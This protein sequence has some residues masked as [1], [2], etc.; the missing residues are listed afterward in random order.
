M[1]LQRG[2]KHVILVVVLLMTGADGGCSSETRPGQ[3]ASDS[4]IQARDD[5]A[6]YNPAGTA[7]APGFVNI[8]YAGY[9]GEACTEPGRVAQLMARAF[10]CPGGGG[11]C[12]EQICVCA[13][14]KWSC[15]CSVHC[16]AGSADVSGSGGG[17]GS[18]GGG[19]SPVSL[20][21]LTCTCDNRTGSVQCQVIPD[22]GADGDDAGDVLD[23]GD[24]GDSS[25]LRG[26]AG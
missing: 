19:G 21:G 13:D 6:T 15:A 16:T 2:A 11:D 8:C 9:E 3:G 12:P 24:A 5:S 25:D 26:D 22:A 4:G 10:N 7:G 18:A 23:G 20:P 14:S 17:A 1:T